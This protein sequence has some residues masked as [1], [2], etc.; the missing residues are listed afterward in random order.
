M[1]APLRKGRA[2]ANAQRLARGFFALAF[3]IETIRPA[4][5]GAVEMRRGTRETLSGGRGATSPRRG[6]A[7]RTPCNVSIVASKFPVEARQ[8][9]HEIVEAPHGGGKLAQREQPECRRRAA[10]RNSARC[11][12]SPRSEKVSGSDRRA[13][14]RAACSPFRD[15]RPASV[16]GRGLSVRLPSGIFDGGAVDMRYRTWPL[17]CCWLRLH[18]LPHAPARAGI[19]I[20]QA[21]ISRGDLVVVGRSDHPRTEVSLDGQLT[22]KTSRSGR[23]TLRGP[24]LPPGCVATVTAGGESRRVVISRCAPGGTPG[25]KGEP[26]AAGA[27]GPAGA[28]APLVRRDL[29]ARKVLPEH[30]APPDLRA[31]QG[32]PA[33]GDLQASAGQ[34]EPRA[35]PA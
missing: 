33:P 35:L 1:P 13:C 24:Y 10:H 28:R 8:L 19:D 6:S 17:T 27:R 20:W 11:A 2:S 7:R 21:T 9:A 26:G 3:L 30:K 4:L 34:P 12:R 5:G 32:R 29:P 14:L 18:R 25:A 22:G 15:R 16:D 23:F 31:P